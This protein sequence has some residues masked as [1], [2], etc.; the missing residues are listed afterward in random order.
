[1]SII[2]EGFFSKECGRSLCS[3]LSSEYLF[4]VFKESRVSI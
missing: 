3:A 4:D 1:M 2:F